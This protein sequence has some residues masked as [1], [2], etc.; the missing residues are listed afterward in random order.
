MTY[1]CIALC[2]GCP[3]HHDLVHTIVLFEG[4][5]VLADGLNLHTT[6]KLTHKTPAKVL[7]I[8]V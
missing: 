7:M 4:T 3:Q 8:D 1:L 2:V 5:D 6:T